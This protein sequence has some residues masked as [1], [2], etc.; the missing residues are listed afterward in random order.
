MFLI[1]DEK[2]LQK[3]NEIWK[4][5]CNIIKNKIVIKPVYNEQ[6]LNYLKTKI[7]V[8]DNKKPI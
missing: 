6:Y 5:A 7:K 8:Y 4:K 3:Y 2:L 1:K